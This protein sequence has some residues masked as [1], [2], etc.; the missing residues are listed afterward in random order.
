MSRPPS[1][2]REVVIEHAVASNRI[3]GSPGYPDPD[4]V[5][6]ERAK[7]AYDRC[8]NPAGVA[9]QLAGIVAGGDR[10][11]LLMQIDVPCLVIHGADDPLVPLSHGQDTA[12]KVPGAKLEVID[13]M[14]HDLPLALLPRLADLIAG[15]ALGV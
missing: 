11:D 5:V 12:D 15:H 9:R 14:G 4:D 6:Y 3:I 7:A 10:S 2:E 8:Y 13:G 1:Q